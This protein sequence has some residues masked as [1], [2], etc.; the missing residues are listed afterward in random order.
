LC[1]TESTKYKSIR[2]KTYAIVGFVSIPTYKKCYARAYSTQLPESP[3]QHPAKW[4]SLGGHI[5]GTLHLEGT[6]VR[7]PVAVGL[8]L[9]LQVGLALALQV[10]LALALQVRLPVGLALL[11]LRIPYSGWR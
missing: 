1:G 11:V 4:N 2:Y 9:A 7:L 10:G 6:L 3:T 8:V 5:E